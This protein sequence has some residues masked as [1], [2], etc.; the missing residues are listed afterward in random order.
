MTAL[1]TSII[2]ARVDNQNTSDM[3]K[4]PIKLQ[5]QVQTYD[6]KEVIVKKVPPDKR[7][8]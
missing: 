5:T 6:S 8:A 7:R 4:P 2:S 3:L 1:N